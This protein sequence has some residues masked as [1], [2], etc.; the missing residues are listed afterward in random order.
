MKRLLLLVLVASIGFTQSVSLTLNSAILNSKLNRLSI[1]DFDFI[2]AGKSQNLF[3]GIVNINSANETDIDFQL[4]F[5]FTYNG[6]KVVSAKT[7]LIRK[8]TTQTISFSNTQFNDNIRINT[9]DGPENLTFDDLSINDDAGLISASRISAKL[10]DGQY[11][12]T[13]TAEL[14]RIVGDQRV[15]IEPNGKDN[16]DLEFFLRQNWPINLMNPVGEVNTSSPL[17]Q[18]DSRASQYPQVTLYVWE[19]DGDKSS[20]IN[21]TPILKKVYVNQDNMGIPVSFAFPADNNRPLE[22]GKKYFWTV[23]VSIV[24]AASR[25]PQ[26]EPNEILEFVYKKPSNDNI[27]STAVDNILRQLLGSAGFEIYQ[28]EFAGFTLE[29]MTIN[30]EEARINNLT[31]YIQK[32][33]NGEYNL[34]VETY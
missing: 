6:K 1:N 25:N 2:G 7:D 27:N 28:K 21:K 16:F 30:G 11:K 5:D 33:V 24:T 15:I 8:V 9:L 13:V 18:W 32:L 23:R 10:P 34:L 29:E 14:S 17:F 3:T 26:E 31:Q 20:S 19:N 22:D 12:L 4:F